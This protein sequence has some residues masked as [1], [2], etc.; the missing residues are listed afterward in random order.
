MK[1]YTNIGKL[2]AKEIHAELNV[3]LKAFAEARGL[4][5]TA[6]N[7][8]YSDGDISFNGMNFKVKGK[9]SFKDLQKE[10]QLNQALSIYG[11]T[12]E[13]KNNK[14]IVEYRSRS[15]KF[16]VIYKN[17]RDGKLYK[18]SVE[19]AKLMFAA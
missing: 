7:G 17:L 15:Y 6:G 13:V 2:E 12:S 3:L 8:K 4:E 5:F 19:Q 14:Q 1:Q 11:L 18:T 16:P 9:K 10:S